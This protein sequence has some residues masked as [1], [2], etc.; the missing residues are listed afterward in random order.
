MS[1]Q[2]FRE[3]LGDITALIFEKKESAG[4]RKS[5]TQKIKKAWVLVKVRPGKHT[6]KCKINSATVDQIMSLSP[7]KAM[8]I[9]MDLFDEKYSQKKVS[10][11]GLGK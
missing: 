4:R 1:D 7:I 10:F 3:C 6:I 8:R 2:I 11:G 9:I 5:G